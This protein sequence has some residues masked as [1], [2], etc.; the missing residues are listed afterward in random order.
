LV[1]DEDGNEKLKAYPNSTMN[2]FAGRKVENGAEEVA[3]LELEIG[4]MPDEYENGVYES[5]VA[6][7]DEDA[8]T[9]WMTGFD[10]A[11]HQ[12]TSA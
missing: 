11:E 2:T 5:P 6:E 4:V 10:P 9:E 7:G 1:E 3:E 8:V 12:V